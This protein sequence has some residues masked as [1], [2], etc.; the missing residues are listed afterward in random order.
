VISFLSTVISAVSRI[1]PSG[2]ST[3]AAGIGACLLSVGYLLYPDVFPENC[4]NQTLSDAE[5][6]SSLDEGRLPGET[7]L[8]LFPFWEPG[9]GDEPNPFPFVWSQKE[10]PTSLDF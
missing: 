3:I 6:I 10:F 1:L 4:P 9:P 2:G 8:K 5:D 7:F